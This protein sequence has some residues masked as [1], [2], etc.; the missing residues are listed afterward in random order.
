MPWSMSWK[1]QICC[2]ISLTSYVPFIENLAL[3]YD[4]SD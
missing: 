2:Y 3:L 1:A 4:F